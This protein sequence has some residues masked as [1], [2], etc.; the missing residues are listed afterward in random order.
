MT[1]SCRDKKPWAQNQGCLP[2]KSLSG[3]AE[4]VFAGH[5]LS[6]ILQTVH[7]WG[8]TGLVR[9]LSFSRLE[10]EVHNTLHIY[11][12]CGIFYFPWHRHQIEGTNGL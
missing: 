4:N 7:L 5:V 10:C 3:S 1:N 2:R 9:D 11:P 12:L 6:Y 8:N